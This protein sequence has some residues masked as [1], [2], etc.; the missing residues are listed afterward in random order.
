MPTRPAQAAG[1]PDVERLRRKRPE[2]KIHRFPFGGETVTTHHRATGNIIDIY[3]CAC[4]TPIL[5]RDAS[6]AQPSRPR[7]ANR[8]AT[9]EAVNS[10]VRPGGAVA[11][12]D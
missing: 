6:I 11:A 8:L 9:A 2:G 10:P 5:H 7:I 1:F 4:H 3:I 12:L